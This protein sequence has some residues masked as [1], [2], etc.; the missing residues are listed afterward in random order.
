MIEGEPTKT[1]NYVY[2]NAW[3]DQLT[4]FDGSTIVYDSSGN[5]TSYLGATLTWSR[6]RLLTHYAKGSLNIDIQYD[7]KGIRKSKQTILPYTNISTSYI[8]D[9]NGRLRTEIKN[10]VSRRYLYS[11][12]GI[13]GYIENG[14]QFLYRKNLFGDITAIYK[15]VNKVAEYRYDAWGNCK[16]ILD[17]NGYGSQNPFRYRAYYFDTDLQLYY[18]MT[19][20]YDPKTGRFINADTLE[21]LDPNKINGLNLYAYCRN[22]PIMCVDYSGN[23]PVSIALSCFFALLVLTAV[24][25]ID[26]LS[27]FKNGDYD[28][29]FDGIISEPPETVLMTHSTLSLIDNY[30]VGG[31]LANLSFTITGQLYDNK[32]LIYSFFDKG[33]DKINSGVGIDIFGLL[34]FNMYLST[35]GGLGINLQFTPFTTVGFELSL[36]EG[37]SISGGVVWNNAS[38]EVSANIGLGGLLAVAVSYPFIVYGP[39]ALST[40]GS[41]LLSFA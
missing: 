41:F 1:Y 36:L 32:K 35:N 16:M 39:S 13:I 4:G 2:G 33:E 23:D 26:N 25:A 3:K 38:Y 28:G 21:Y 8:Y 29:Y 15:G 9:S 30:R 19:R 7:A 22:N 6:G 11:S 18:L 10:G 14:E 24:V 5:P 37:L 40:V 17:I 27:K 12:D 34:G 31:I 20:Y